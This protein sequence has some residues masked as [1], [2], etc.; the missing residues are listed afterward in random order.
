MIVVQIRPQMRSLGAHFR[1]PCWP[2]LSRMRTGVQGTPEGL[3]GA[4]EEP[5]LSGS[6]Q[7]PL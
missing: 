4:M 1:G 6:L 3:E 7:L 2:W 5:L